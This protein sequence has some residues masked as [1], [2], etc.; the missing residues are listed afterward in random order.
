MARKGNQ[1]KNGVDRHT[2]SHRKKGSNSGSA[3]P[4][5]TGQGRD[6]KVKVFPGDELPNGSHSGISSA[7]SSSNDHHAGD[8]SIRKNNAEASPRREKQGTDTRR[9]LGQSVSSE[10]SETIAGDSTDNISSRETCGVRIENARRGRKHRKTGLGWSLNRVHLKNM[11]EKVKLSVNVVVRSLRV[12]VVP[13]LKAAIELLERQSP[14]LMTNIYNAHDYVSRKVQQVYPVALNHLGHF[15][16]IMLLLSMLWLDCTIRGIDSFMRMGTTSFFS[17]IWCSIL[18]VI[19]MVGMFKFLM[20][21][22][23][24]DYASCCH[25]IE[26]F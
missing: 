6:G 15:A 17:V 22:V 7:D 20:V 12:Y 13:T 3:V 4:D 24:P 26:G 23:S 18:S 9:D 14:M 2:S 11:M 8:E 16:K 1:Q 19:A 5:M 25:S 21:L 10:T